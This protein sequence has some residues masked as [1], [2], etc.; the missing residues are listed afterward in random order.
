MNE[1]ILIE[2]ERND[3]EIFI[4]GLIFCEAFELLIWLHET[5]ACRSY[6]NFAGFKNDANV[7]EFNKEIRKEDWQP[8]YYK[9]FHTYILF[10][11]SRFFFQMQVKD[12]R[13]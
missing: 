10:K 7:L 4:L 3:M 9:I 8:F 12:W 1:F 11:F 13:T 5:N 2:I 6:L